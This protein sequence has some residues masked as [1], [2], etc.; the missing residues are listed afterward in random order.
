MNPQAAR[1]TRPADARPPSGRRTRKTASSHGSGSRVAAQSEACPSPQRKRPPIIHGERVRDFDGDTHVGRRGFGGV[2]KPIA[3][4]CV[5]RSL[6]VDDDDRAVADLEYAIA[7][8]PLIDAEIVE[9]AAIRM[10]LLRH[11][12]KI[13]AAAEELGHTRQ[14]L[15][16]RLKKYG[17]YTDRTMAR[18]RRAR[19]E[20]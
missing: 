7:R 6:P 18:K 11:N 2:L 4:P 3:K 14:W 12:G 13:T 1:F 20:R 15:Y 10:A 19:S 17:L 16:P 5:C 9:R 8:L